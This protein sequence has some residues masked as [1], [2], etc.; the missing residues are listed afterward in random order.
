LDITEGCEKE[1]RKHP[2]TLPSF[3]ALA[4]I[5]PYSKEITFNHLK[6]GAYVVSSLHINLT[7][8]ISKKE[9]DLLEKNPHFKSEIIWGLGITSVREE[10][11]SVMIYVHFLEHRQI[12]LL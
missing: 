5:Q 11:K 1:E 2:S 7:T 6:I 4:P 9:C 12:Y 10:M 8:L 3:K